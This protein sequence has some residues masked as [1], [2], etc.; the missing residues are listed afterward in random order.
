MHGSQKQKRQ[1]ALG[2]GQAAMAAVVPEPDRVFCPP[3]SPCLSLPN[4]RIKTNWLIQHERKL[5]RWNIT[6][7]PDAPHLGCGLSS[8]YSSHPNKQSPD[9]NLL[10][11][12]QKQG[13]EGGG[14]RCVE[15]SM[16]ICTSLAEIQRKTPAA[17]ASPHT[18]S[19]G[20]GLNPHPCGKITPS[21]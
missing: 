17:A 4:K 10:P 20:D 7:V 16:C 19:T 18:T 5:V 9:F 14:G 12:P 6:P 21:K 8:P 1:A 11:Y 15:P 13:G 2:A 3:S